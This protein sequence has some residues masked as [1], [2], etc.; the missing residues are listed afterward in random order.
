MVYLSI[1]NHLLRLSP[2][3]RASLR[4]YTDRSFSLCYSNQ[5]MNALIGE[6]GF[7]QNIP[8]PTEVKITLGQSAVLK[9]IRHEIPDVSD[10]T[11]EGADTLGLA[12]LPL[13]GA[14]RYE[15]DAD[16]MR[17]FGNQW[18]GFLAN[19][20]LAAKTHIEQL[21]QSVSEQISDYAH[22]NASLLVHQHDFTLW[23]D[24]VNCLINDLENLQIRIDKLQS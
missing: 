10:V 18:G 14:L 21:T 5:M 1:I 4:A 8:V 19:R 2:E 9:I 23:S 16:L 17:L 15:P 13:L 7:L 12:L 22:E 6:E 3:I 11:L 24:N 20:L